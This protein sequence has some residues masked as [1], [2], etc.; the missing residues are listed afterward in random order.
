[1]EETTSANSDSADT[2]DRHWLCRPQV[3]LSAAVLIMVAIAPLQ[4]TWTLFTTSMSE[5]ND[6]SL[7]QVQLA[8]TF[9]V[10][11]QTFVQ[12]VGG[13]LMDHRG[14]RA[15]HALAALLIIVG[16]IGLGWTSHL[17]ALYSLYALVGTG[18][19]LAYAGAIASAIRWFPER[20]GFALGL[21]AAGFGAG[22]APFIPIIEAVIQQYGYTTAFAISGLATAAI[23]GIAGQVLRHPFHD[24]CAHVRE[25]SANGPR[26]G[27]GVGPRTLL[28]RS[29]FWLAYSAFLFM[30]TGLLVLTANAKPLALDLGLTTTV[31]V[32]AVS[33]QQVMNGL[34]RVFWGW[35]SDKLGRR[36]TM[37]SAFALDGLI[38][39][40]IP[41]AGAS[42]FGFVILTSLAFFTAGEIFALFPA[43]TADL[44][45]TRYAAGNQGLLYTAKGLAALMGGSFAAWLAT[46]QS[47]LLV[48][49][50][51]G[52]LAF[53]SAGIMLALRP[54]IRLPHDGYE[55]A[56]E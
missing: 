27:S 17:I 54:A 20:R 19:G 11:T 39:I 34:S 28:R 5:A 6:W 23:V 8:F 55:V 15:V 38:L 37:V 24:E 26:R 46:S 2:Q 22:A 36:R 35:V 18:A 14:P 16:W 47:W 9:F 53:A 12:P 48:F 45:G 31:L 7:A 3:Q 41:L 40:L 33:L 56:T 42:P 21:V 10:V 52:L 29:Q 25:M 43:F 4:Y 13:Y 32:I 1:M 44:F 49:A 50:L 51:A 30:A